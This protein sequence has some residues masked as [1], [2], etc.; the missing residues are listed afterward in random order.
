LILAK[1]YGYANLE[2]R[3]PVVADQTLFRIGSTSKLFVWTGVMQLVEQGRL[4]LNADINIY[5]KTFKIPATFSQPITMLHLMTHTAGFEE[6]NVATLARDANSLVSLD[7]YLKRH[8]PARVRPP[9]KYTAY[10]NYGAALASYIVEEIT[11]VTFEQY[12]E[13]NIFRPL[14]MTRSTLRQPVPTELQDAVSLGYTFQD[15]FGA[16]PFEYF[17]VGSAGAVSATA[18]DM[19][20]F[21]LAHLQAGLYC[22][23][24]S[25]ARS[26]NAGNSIRILQAATAE[27]MRQR[28]F[29]NDPRLNGFAYGFFDVRMNQMRVLEHGGRT[30]YFHSLLVLVPEKRIGVF[31]VF[32]TNTA[33]TAPA[34]FMQDFL[35]HY[36]PM[37]ISKPEQT[38]SGGF[39]PSQSFTGTF[40][41]LRSNYTGIERIFS[42]RGLGYAT[43]SIDPKG[44]LALSATMPDQVLKERF[45]Q[46]ERLLYRSADGTD[47]LVLAQDEQSRITHFFLDS[48]PHYAFE[49]IAWYEELS[50]HL[51]SVVICLMLFTSTIFASLMS[52]LLRIRHRG[53]PHGARILALGVSVLYGLLVMG[54]FRFQI[55]DSGVFGIPGYLPIALAFGV[56]AAVLTVGMLACA[57]LAW[58]RSYWSLGGRIHYTMVTVA[59]IGFAWFLNYWN[60][61]GWHI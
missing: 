12:V 55:D 45:V 34:K 59:A 4:D 32:N 48:R 15:S 44:T 41:W 28:L 27:Q 36:Y 43:I 58:T 7:E 19:A 14:E 54:I 52:A 9:G 21:M 1:G 6:T 49:K 13:E 37:A 31:I 57:L 47:L 39:Q 29:A 17:N 5:L 30:S 53:L 2:Q 33:V 51:A 23:T 10:S 61:L 8:I 40:R 18:T 3:T 60:L 16:R 46:V 56:G 11:N 22:P 50:L 25:Q 24:P 26:S 42:L 38:S 35:D 20:K